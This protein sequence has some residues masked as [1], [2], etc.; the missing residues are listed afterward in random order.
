MNS[1]D[2]NLIERGLYDRNFFNKIEIHPVLESTNVLAK[3]LAE[4]GA[5]NGT[6]II[7]NHQT[8]GKGRLGRSFY[9][10]PNS[11]IYMSI[12]LRPTLSADCALLITSAAGVAVCRAIDKICGLYCDIK[13]VNDIYINNKKICG[14]SA[15]A[16]MDFQSYTLKYVVLGIG[17]NITTDDFPSEL[18]PKADSIK[19]HA[20]KADF[21]RNQLI[22]QVLNEIQIVYNDLTKKNFIFEYRN[23]SCVI[24]RD[25]NVITGETSKIAF[26]VDINEFGHLIVKNVDGRIE[27]LNTGEVSIR[28]I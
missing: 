12:V 2:L 22:S 20:T 6:V 24:G 5:E 17:I 8:G 23:R 1:L 11:G 13:W 27:A 26:A 10:P 28:L 15:E 4:N 25:I 14:I 19:K 9:S 18:T 3:D 16:S 7:A 21:S